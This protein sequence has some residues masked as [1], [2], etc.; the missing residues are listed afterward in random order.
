MARV[1]MARLWRNQVQN[2]RV[3]TVAAQLLAAHILSGLFFKLLQLR[4][5]R[6]RAGHGVLQ[7]IQ[8]QRLQVGHH[9]LLHL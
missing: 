6:P 7:P 1:P 2:R 4:Q 5:L 9:N 8:A 3:Y